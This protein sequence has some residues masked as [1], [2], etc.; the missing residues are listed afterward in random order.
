[1]EQIL[2]DFVDY[3]KSG[4][5]SIV[6]YEN[7][8]TFKDG[9]TLVYHNIRYDISRFQGNEIITYSIHTQFML[10]RVDW[11]KPVTVCEGIYHDHEFIHKLKSDYNGF[12]ISKWEA[13]SV[14]E[15]DVLICNNKLYSRCSVG[16]K[17]Q[18]SLKK[19]VMLY[20][21]PYY[22]LDLAKYP[23]LKCVISDHDIGVYPD[24]ALQILGANIIVNNIGISDISSYEYI[25][26]SYFAENRFKR[27]GIKN[28]LL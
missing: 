21:P 25:Y 27:A 26:R 11:S 23:E 1:M 12:V 15:Y 8:I 5:N 4:N 20:I 3:C 2:S 13:H 19:V 28:Q 6:E 14:L 7:H 17:K 16:A 9:K 22:S 10:A 24:L 18:M